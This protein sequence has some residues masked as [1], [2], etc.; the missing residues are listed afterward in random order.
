MTPIPVP[1]TSL[2][3]CQYSSPSL[4]PPTNIPSQLKFKREVFEVSIKKILIHTKRFIKKKNILP[5][6][7]ERISSQRH[8]RLSPIWISAPSTGLSITCS[9]RDYTHT[10]TRASRAIYNS[11][12]RR[13]MIPDVKDLSEGRGGIEEFLFNILAAISLTS[14]LRPPSSTSPFSPM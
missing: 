2:L 13:A 1:Q 3:I 4:P 10:I 5:T 9:A 8:L 6:A 14:D 12:N 11:Y 7:Q